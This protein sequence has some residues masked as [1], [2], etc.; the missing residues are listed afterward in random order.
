MS[1]HD[2]A[3]AKGSSSVFLGTFNMNG[4]PLSESNARKWL[5]VDRKN[6]D[7]SKNTCARNADLVLL[8]FQECP[9][10]CTIS[11]IPSTFNKDTTFVPCVMTMDGNSVQPEGM[12]D[13]LPKVLSKTLS[14]EHTLVADLSM[15]EPPYTP[16]DRSAQ[17]KWFGFIRLIVYAKGGKK[18]KLVFNL[19]NSRFL[20]SISF[21]FLLN[22]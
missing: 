6:Q 10:C 12:V 14:V 3:E 5:Q 18:M 9:T 22:R 2:S 7:T 11:S 1:F 13:D 15:G 4:S 19:D 16:K 8:S 17:D 21:H 20:I